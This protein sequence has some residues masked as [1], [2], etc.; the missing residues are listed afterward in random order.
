MYPEHQS[1]NETSGNKQKDLNFVLNSADS[2]TRV[3]SAVEHLLVPFYS[4][5]SRNGP[6]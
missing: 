1:L 4:R 3:P 5:A 6:V 2:Q